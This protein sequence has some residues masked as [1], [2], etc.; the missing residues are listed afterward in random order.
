MSFPSSQQVGE[1]RALE[2]SP[3]AAREVLDGGDASNAEYLQRTCGVPPPSGVFF[4]LPEWLVDVT[5]EGGVSA[6]QAADEAA[7][8]RL[9]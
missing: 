3:V 6:A 5:S 2:L 9:S 8:K 1:G 4:S 7:P